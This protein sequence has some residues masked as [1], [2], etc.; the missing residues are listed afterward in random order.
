MEIPAFSEVELH[1]TQWLG[2]YVHGWLVKAM[3]QKTP[4]IVANAVGEPWDKGEISVI[5]LQLVNPLPYSI[6]IHKNVSKL[7][8]TVIVSV[9]NC[10]TNVHGELIQDT[11]S[12]DTIS[13][14]KYGG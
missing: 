14:E 9:V 4:F 8:H 13:P 7:D 12:A 1:T 5:P 6:T 10:D 2:T 3:P 11:P